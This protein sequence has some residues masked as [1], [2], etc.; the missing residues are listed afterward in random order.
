[1]AGIDSEADKTALTVFPNPVG[2]NLTVVYTA[3][4]SA[5][6]FIKVVDAVGH[7]VLEN[8]T[9]SAVGKNFVTLDLRA[10][11]NGL[12]LLHVQTRETINIQKIKVSK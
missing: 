12:Y 7:N 1:M 9:L 10:L 5:E 6:T 11:P 4:E 3:N 2:D 8:N